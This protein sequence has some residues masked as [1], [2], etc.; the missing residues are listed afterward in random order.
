MPPSKNIPL[1]TA[2]F[3]SLL[4]LLSL[5]LSTLTNAFP[6]HPGTCDITQMAT[7]GHQASL[8]QCVGCYSL[9]LTRITTGTAFIPGSNTFTITLTGPRPVKGLLL[10]ALDSATE[11]R[12]GSFQDY[13]KQLQSLSCGGVGGG[14]NTLGHEK[15]DLKSM[16]MT[17]QWTDLGYAKQAKGGTWS[18]N[19]MGIAVIDFTDWYFISNLQFTSVTNNT[20]LAASRPNSTTKPVGT[21]VSA[22]TPATDA[23]LGPDGLPSALQANTILNDSH[24]FFF[25]LLVTLG[26]W[27]S[28]S[29]IEHLL[30]RQESVARAE[31]RDRKRKKEKA[32]L[33]NVAGAGRISRA[34]APR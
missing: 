5:L 4:F 22:S 6:T 21:V 15:T 29:W 9:S 7:I 19:M 14:A 28:G 24:I 23:S 3:L 13:P 17:M 12:F 10:Y 32:R 8:S 33:N 30:R 27:L 1:H 11:Q 31:A 18:A 20:G 34:L 25:A 2:T 26:L 16:P